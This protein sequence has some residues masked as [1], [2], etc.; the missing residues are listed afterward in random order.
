MKQANSYKT[1]VAKAYNY[2]CATN[3]LEWEKP[4]YRTDDKIPLIPTTE[5][6][7]KI[8]SA[9]TEK[10]ATIFTILAEI[11][12]EAHEVEMVTR[13]D[14][15][16]EKGIIT[17]KGC[18][19]HAPRTFKLKQQ[20]AEMLR[21]YLF[22]HTENNPFPKSEY[23]GKIW[24]RTRNKL[25]T[26][27]QD[28]QLKQIPMRNLRNYS[29]AQLYYKLQDP[30][31]VMRHLGHKKLETTMH[32]LKGIVINGEEEYTCKTATTVQEAQ[33]LIEAGFQYFTEM[34]GLTIQ[35]TQI[36]LSFF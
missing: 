11:G 7:K 34:D 9:S 27:I 35:K 1:A 24:R 13:K 28:P 8:I 17:A 36:N 12:L 5:N 22:K 18:K 25:A 33:T 30:I 26:K 14:I 16:T 3:G 6:V 10:Y 15:D 2:L 23:M 21:I 31:A 20:T 32:Y 19:G 29:G 4:K